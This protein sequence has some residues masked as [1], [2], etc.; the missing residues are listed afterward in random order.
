MRQ[1]ESEDHL[2]VF[3]HTPAPKVKHAYRRPTVSLVL[4][5]NPSLHLR[6]GR[7]STF[8]WGVPGLRV[9]LRWLWGGYRLASNTH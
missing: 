8:A 5:L 2:G 7:T 1:Q 3:L 6:R 9:A 4:G